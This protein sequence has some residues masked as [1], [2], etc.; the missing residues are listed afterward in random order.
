MRMRILVLALLIALLASFD[1]MAQRLSSTSGASGTRVSVGSTVTF[2]IKYTNV[3]GDPVSGAGILFFFDGDPA[4]GAT[5]NANGNASKSKTYNRT[6][7]YKCTATVPCSGLRSAGTVNWSFRVGNPHQG[8]ARTTS[9]NP[10]TY[11]D[12]LANNQSN[13]FGVQKQPTRVSQPSYTAP[14]HTPEPEPMPNRFTSTY[15]RRHLRPS[16]RC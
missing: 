12:P 9:N 8:N 2:G 5:T 13:A 16:T 7:V 10:P 3:N 14:M 6:G 1:V 15:P 11:K 4:V